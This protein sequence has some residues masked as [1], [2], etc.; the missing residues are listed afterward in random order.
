MRTYPIDL[1]P[2]QVVQW[3]LGEGHVEDN[4]LSVRATRFFETGALDGGQSRRLG[5]EEREEIGEVVEVGLLEVRPRLHSD[6]WAL[7][8]RVADDIGPRTPEDEAVPAEEEEIDL[9]AF[10]EE[11]LRGDRGLPELTGEARDEA[12]E[13][14]LDRLL[15]TIV[16]RQASPG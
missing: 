15:Q 14:D 11:F 7:R 12:A 6:R 1:E 13:A 5:D 4:R 2:E 8:L 3:L 10:R 16:A 9:A